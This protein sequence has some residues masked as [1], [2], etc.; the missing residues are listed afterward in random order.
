[1]NCETYKDLSLFEQINLIGK[2]VHIVQNSNTACKDV[3]QLV[4]AAEKSGWL[5]GVTILP[6]RQQAPLNEKEEVMP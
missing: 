1:M 4:Q 2:L 6:E 3:I 5:D